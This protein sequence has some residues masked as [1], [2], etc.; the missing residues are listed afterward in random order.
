MSVEFGLTSDEACTE[1][2]AFSLIARAIKE[3]RPYRFVLLD[4]DDP[5][6]YVGRFISSLEKLLEVAGNEEISMDVYACSEN[7][8][9]QMVRKCQ[10][11]NVAF[12]HKPL[13]RENCLLFADKYPPNKGSLAITTSANQL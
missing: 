6:V 1:S 11:H 4:L 12:L 13:T 3:S 7:N 8:S 9:E 10:T 2:Q 5:T